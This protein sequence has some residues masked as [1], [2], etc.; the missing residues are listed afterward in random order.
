VLHPA[1]APGAPHVAV[2]ADLDL[3]RAQHGQELRGSDDDGA[4]RGPEVLG[5]R[6]THQSLDHLAELHV[7]GGEVVDK[8]ET[9]QHAQGLIGCQVG[10][11]PGDDDPDL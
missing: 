4:E 7:A 1:G 11:V 2:D 9:A 6:R 5:L 3:Q 8:H 10:A